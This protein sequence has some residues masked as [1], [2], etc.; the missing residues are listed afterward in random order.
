MNNAPSAN[1]L[2]GSK[3]SGAVDS[4]AAAFAAYPLFRAIAANADDEPKVRRACL[5]FV[6]RHALSRGLVY[7]TPDHGATACWLRPGRE[8][9]DP[10]SALGTGG[11]SLVW[12]LGW[13]ASLALDRFT[14]AADT[15]R[16][17]HVR[18]PH[19]F[20]LVVGVR[21]DRQRQGLLRQV[22]QPVFEAADRDRL[23]CLL[24]TM[25]ETNVGIYRRLGFEVF[26]EAEALGCPIWGMRREP[27]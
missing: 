17:T 21:P 18:G 10:L 13:R 12:S 4:L 7:S 8:W 11:L 27:A 6:V 20:L 15:L 1:R 14:R 5:R 9:V 2:S 22:L 16:R 3:A 26:G 24:D 23:P 25:T 19:W